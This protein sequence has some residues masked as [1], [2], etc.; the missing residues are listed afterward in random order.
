M[1]I[2]CLVHGTAVMC[3]T[4]KR[5]GS[6]RYLQGHEVRRKTVE[7]SCKFVQVPAK[8]LSEL[9][10][11]IVCEVVFSPRDPT[12]SIFRPKIGMVIHGHPQAN[13]SNLSGWTPHH[14]PGRKDAVLK[15]RDMFFLLTIWHKNISERQTLIA[16]LFISIITVCTYTYTYI[17]ILYMYTYIYRHMF[18]HIYIYYSNDSPMIVP[19]SPG[20]VIAGKGRKQSMVLLASFCRQ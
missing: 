12:C 4:A 13:S 6:T 8:V 19:W 17:Y 10:E 20:S 14:R 16:N 5:S 2:P 9:N 1:H 7:P 3:G 18:I 11:T 15:Y